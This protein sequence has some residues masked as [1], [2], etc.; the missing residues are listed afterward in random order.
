VEDEET[1]PEEEMPALRQMVP[2]GSPNHEAPEV[3]REA[4]LPESPKADNRR[5]QERPRK[6]PPEGKG[7]A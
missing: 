2:A 7:R 4:R 5:P 1:M 3:L 6:V